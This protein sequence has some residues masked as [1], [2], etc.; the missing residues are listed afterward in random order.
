MAT[1]RLQLQL[2]VSILSKIRNT[3]LYLYDETIFKMSEKYQP[4]RLEA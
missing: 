4:Q 3:I 2:A 1:E